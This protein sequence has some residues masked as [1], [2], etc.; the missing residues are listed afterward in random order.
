M[1]DNNSRRRF[2]KTASAT[3][4]AG[5]S[6]LAGAQSFDFKPNQRYPDPSV[7]VL[8]P[9]FAKYRLYSSTVEQLGSG[10]RWAEGPAYSVEGG[11]LLLS[12]I[13][14]NRLM[15][16]DEKTGKFGVFK[17]GVNYTNGNVFDRQGRL[18][19]C[20]HSVTRRIV[21][22]EKNGKQTVL[23]DNYEGKRLNA[24]NDIVVKSD[25]SIWFTDPTFGIGGEWEGFK[26]RPEQAT[27]NVYRIGKDGKLT[28][29]ITE[30][31]NPN[32]LAFSPDEKKLYVV[33]WKG[34]P[35]RSIWSYDVSDDG[36]T[37]S[38]KTKLIDADGPG[39]FDGFKVDRDG[40]LWCGWGYTG[41][42]GTETTDIGAGMKALTPLGKPEEMDGVKIF[43]PQGK[44]IGFIKLPERCPNLVF[45]GPKRNRLYMASSH[46]LYALYVEA[47]GAV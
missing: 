42:F 12:D 4:I 38:N 15:K 18:I 46:S 27:T 10:M 44:P 9:S 19:S 34:T 29:V 22:T 21:R 1:Q 39:A 13:P 47:F 40:N 26:A 23:A 3:G 6:G 2:L 37:V 11:Y 14:N 43:N 25:D 36:T 33:E 16:Y 24:P 31:V 35:N 7:Y 30:L 41:A 20:E 8:D 45:G 32:G 17:T 5:L 28:A